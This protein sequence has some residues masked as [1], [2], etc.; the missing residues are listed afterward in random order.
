MW[1]PLG[2][3]RG[4]TGIALRAI[5]YV[6]PSSELDGSA[7]QTISRTL[8]RH[9]ACCQTGIQ[10]PTPVAVAPT[11]RIAMEGECEET[12]EPHFNASGGGEAIW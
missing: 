7:S 6:E 11:A 9:E 4:L 3:L 8:H 1:L 10:L 12:P 5:S 2:P